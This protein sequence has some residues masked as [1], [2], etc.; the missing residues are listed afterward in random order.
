VSLD[1]GHLY[2]ERPFIHKLGSTFIVEWEQ[3]GV[4]ASAS[5]I[6]QHSDALTAVVTWEGKAG[7]RYVH[8]SE[9]SMNLTS[10]Q[11]RAAVA[12]ALAKRSRVA[13][14][15]WWEGAVEQFSKLVRDKFLERKPEVLLDDVQVPDE[16]PFLVERLLPESN[17]TILHADGQAG[18]SI[19][20]MGLAMSV[21][22]GVPFAGRW[23]VRNPGTVLY[24]DWETSQVDQAIRKRRF[25]AS[26]QFGDGPHRIRYQFMTGSLAAQVGDIQ[27]LVDRYQ[28]V[29]VIYDS[30]GWATGED[31]TEAG[32][33]IR[34]MDASR[35]IG[36]T[37]L[38]LAHVTKDEARKASKDGTTA[39]IFGSKYFELAARYVWY[40]TATQ[41]ELD[42]SKALTLRNTKANNVR[43]S[44]PLTFRMEF[45]AT[46]GPIRIL[47]MAADADL[48]GPTSLS[49][50]LV[51]AL[52]RGAKTPQELMELTG[53][54]DNAIRARLADLERRGEVRKVGES[55][56]GH[57]QRWGLSAPEF[58]GVQPSFVAPKAPDQAA[59]AVAQEDPDPPQEDPETAPVD[60]LEGVPDDEVCA[61]CRGAR[62]DR[63]T[64][65]GLFICPACGDQ[66]Q[67]AMA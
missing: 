26:G 36:P 54:A 15:D 37:G 9:H 34:V 51:T 11:T 38:F 53:A 24:L 48:A 27:K 32:A 41:N 59:E 14:T 66:V 5:T 67:E 12:K 6:H 39:T 18:K 28:P 45:D 40:M 35:E 55:G 50:R 29:L 1:D 8:W 64:P 22:T 31:L 3:M 30:L 42:G 19:F 20:A 21:S 44:E 61:M 33:A 43:R 57:P 62:A 13:D 58:A 65:A 47:D 10:L 2:Q 7:D 56:P 16:P 4:K 63:Y 52:K 23:K 46:A 49:S 60:P 17:T 25:T